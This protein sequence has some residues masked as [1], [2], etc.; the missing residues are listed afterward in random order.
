VTLATHYAFRTNQQT[1][2]DIDYVGFRTTFGTTTISEA[3]VS[4]NN[5]RIISIQ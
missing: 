5:V 4:P 3:P 1:C 2:P